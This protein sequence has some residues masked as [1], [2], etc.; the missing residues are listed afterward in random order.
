M[1]TSRIVELAQRTVANT[2]EIN[3]YITA[4]NL[5]QPSFDVDPPLHSVVPPTELSIGA[6]RQAAIYDCQELRELLLGPTEHLISCRHNE[7]ISQQAILRFGLA[8]AL[9]LRT[10]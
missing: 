4:N 10:G 9:P 6:A 1:S 7:L 8:R 3:D 5:P 2:T